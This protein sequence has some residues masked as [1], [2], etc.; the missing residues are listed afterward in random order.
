MQVAV[1]LSHGD[2]GSW[3]ASAA[4]HPSL[5]ARAWS[6]DDVIRQIECLLRAELGA[7]LQ[8]RRTIATDDHGQ[9]LSHWYNLTLRI[10]RK[11]DEM[12]GLLRGIIADDVVSQR[13]VEKLAEWLLVN[14]EA[15][16]VWPIDVV[17][18]RVGQI[19]EDGVIDD[20]EREDLRAIISEMVATGSDHVYLDLRSYIQRDE[21][22]GAVFIERRHFRDAGAADEGF[23]AGAAD[24]QRAQIIARRKRLDR[25]DELLHQ[26]TVERVE[27]LAV[28]ERKK[29]DHSASA[30]IEPKIDARAFAHDLP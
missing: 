14:Q 8:G 23:A 20:E 4:S 25:G 7:T 11:T 15:T 18:E 27:L 12:I 1:T 29:G 16:V 28:V 21:I 19:L 6:R 5:V 24:Y 3:T 22:L 26:R 2:D 9:P 30:R 13:E 10:R 17:L